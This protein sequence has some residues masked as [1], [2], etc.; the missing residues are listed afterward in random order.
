MSNYQTRIIHARI[1]NLLWLSG[2]LILKTIILL[3]DV[4][5]VGKASRIITG[6]SLFVKIFLI[7]THVSSNIRHDLNIS[8]TV[9]RLLSLEL[10]L[11]CWAFRLL[12]LIFVNNACPTYSLFILIILSGTRP[13]VLRCIYVSNFPSRRS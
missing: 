7:L 5:M 13:C 8:L 10:V 2:A 1:I 9:S 11:H 12:W 6:L 4:R 3:K